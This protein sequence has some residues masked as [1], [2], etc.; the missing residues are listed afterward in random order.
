VLAAEHLLGLAGIDLGAQFVEPLDEVGKDVLARLRPF[1]EHGEIVRTALERLTE[2]EIAF[3]SLAP[4]QDLLRGR[5][6]LP[7]VR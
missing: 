3:E 6:V 4:L 5:L 1:D 7:E 2:I